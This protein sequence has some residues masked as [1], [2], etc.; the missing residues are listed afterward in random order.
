MTVKVYLR[1]S[2]LVRTEIVKLGY[3]S[4]AFAAAIGINANYFS[5]VLNG[6]RNPSP[7]TAKKIAD[8]ININLDKLF[9]VSGVHKNKT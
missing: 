9:I 6:R 8:K 1:D 5:Q 4:K 3:T 7:T 2:N